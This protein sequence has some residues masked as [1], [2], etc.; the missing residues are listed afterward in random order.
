MWH[1]SSFPFIATVMGATTN[2]A[3]GKSDL[4]VDAIYISAVL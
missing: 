3:A 4:F 2:T 1:N